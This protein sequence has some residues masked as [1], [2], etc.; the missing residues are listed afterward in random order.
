MHSLLLILIL[1]LQAFM[2]MADDGLQ[3]TQS[4][5]VGL[6]VSFLLAK[7][8][9]VVFSSVDENRSLT[10]TNPIQHQ[11]DLIPFEAHRQSEENEKRSDAEFSMK[12]LI[13][14]QAAGSDSDDDW[15][16]VE[17]TELDVAF[18]AANDF[19]AAIA[20][21][22]SELKV[23][24]KMRLELY[25][26]YKIATEGAC[27]VPQPSAIKITARAKWNAWHKMSAMSPEEAMQ[28]Y[29]EIVTELFP[30]WAD[31]S[32]Y[33][34]IGGDKNETPIKDTIPIGSDISSSMHDEES[35]NDR[36]DDIHGFAREG[37]A[38]NLSKCNE[39]W[40][41]F[42]FHP[43]IISI[44]E[45]QMHSHRAV[46]GDHIDVAE[47]LLKRNAD[48]NQKDVEGQTPMHYVADCEQGKTDALDVKKNAATGI[49]DDDDGN[50]PSDL[51][52][53]TRHSIQP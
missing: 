34:R 30:S 32:T 33:K 38:N 50:Y 13:D 26:L 19:V 44:S 15:E 28:K 46:D 9:S 7:L 4:V 5:V 40:P 20:A 10:G 52:H 42:I 35:G 2:A 45:D 23:S 1:L 6:I 29:L 49:Q 51:S 37:D 36:L 12:L 16:G 41:H 27:C 14:H 11:P 17:T 3:Y 48:M 39:G 18:C 21:D 53:S 43:I 25:G 31:G 22:R 24:N 8:F 47:M